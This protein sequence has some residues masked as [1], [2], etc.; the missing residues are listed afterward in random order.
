MS[1]LEWSESNFPFYPMPESVITHVKVEEW[2]KQLDITASQ[3]ALKTQT[4]LMEAVHDNLVHGCD[5]EVGHPGNQPTFSNNVFDDPAIDIPRI[6]DAL[7]QEVKMEHMAGP[8]SIGYVPDGKVNGFLSVVKKGGA[9]RQVGNMS[10]PKGVSFNDGIDKSTLAQW[11]VIQTTSKQ[12]AAMIARAGRGATLS[13]S[14]MVSAYKSLPVCVKQQRLQVFHFLGR[15]F[16][17]L[18]LI[19]GD[20]AACMWFDRFHHCIVAFFVLP[21]APLPRGWVGRTIDDLTTVCPSTATDLTDR[22][23][24]VYREEL[25]RLGISAA[26]EDPSRCKAFDGNTS[27]EIL[28]VWFDTISM[29]W[30]LSDSKISVLV[31]QLMEA[32]VA[33]ASLSLNDVEVIHGKLSHFCQHAPPLSLLVAETLEFLRELLRQNSEM[34]RGMKG[35]S[36]RRFP[37]PSLMRHDL[38]TAAAIIRMTL[39]NPLPIISMIKTPSLAAV[40]VFTDISG[41]IVANPSMGVYIPARRVERPIVASLAFPR[42]FLTMSDQKDKKVFHKTTMLEGLAFLTTLCL[43]PLRF[44]EGEALFHIDNIA[45]CI[46]LEKGNSSDPWATTVVRAGRVV[47]AGI[48]CSIFAVWERRRSSRASRIADDLTHN[49]FTELTNEEV[50]ALLDFGQVAFPPP[51]LQWMARPSV[52]VGL[53]RRCLIWLRSQFPGLEILRPSLVK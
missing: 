18:R 11:R 12:F 51:V 6:A 26:P 22:F 15:E 10:A 34:F 33:G 3:P 52:D 31:T 23:V 28:G 21:R 17:D 45:T 19:F 2:K 14:D 48:G 8:F 36:T 37:V 9:R 49:L 47:A 42:S 40:K 39:T 7:A 44:V 16:V 50:E 27:G 5:S 46:T 20:K 30:K 13:C 35:R 53:G 1:D 32:S 4:S 25:A 43:D 38:S 29:T 41:H 24:T